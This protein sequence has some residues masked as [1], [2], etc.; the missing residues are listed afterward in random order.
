MV[1]KEV[2]DLSLLPLMLTVDD[3]CSVLRIGRQAT[4]NLVRCGRLRALHIGHSIRIPRDA[5]EFFLRSVLT[6]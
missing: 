6:N 5:V 3:V 4:Y 2:N 1:E